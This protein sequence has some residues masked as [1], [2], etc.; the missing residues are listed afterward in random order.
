M[1]GKTVLK[2]QDAGAGAPDAQRL[3]AVAGYF[4]DRE[5]G[6]TDRLIYASAS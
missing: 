3:R 6:E 4:A 2:R 1:A 5:A